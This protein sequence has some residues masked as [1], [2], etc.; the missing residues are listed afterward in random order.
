MTKRCRLSNPLPDFVIAG[1]PFWRL[2]KNGR[3]MDYWLTE[4]PDGGHE[5]SE[6]AF[7]I[8]A[9]PDWRDADAPVLPARWAPGATQRW[10]RE[11]HD[12]QAQ[13]LASACAVQ[14]DLLAASNAHWIRRPE[15]RG[16]G[17]FAAPHLDSDIPF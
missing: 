12:Y 17:S 13:V 2:R 8:R 10:F 15:A 1:R 7:D 16:L 3:R 6:Q 9:L 4:E 5:G 14:V 11:L